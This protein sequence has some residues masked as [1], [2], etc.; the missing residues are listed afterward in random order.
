[1]LESK[2]GSEGYLVGIEN[3]VNCQQ[4]YC[5]YYY[6]HQLENCVQIPATHCCLTNHHKH[7]FHL[8]CSGSGVELNLPFTFKVSLNCVGVL[9]FLSRL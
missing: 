1:M 9:F 8:F 6:I 3:S 2:A 5:N 4:I 7:I